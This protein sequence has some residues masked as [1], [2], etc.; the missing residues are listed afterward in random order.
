MEAYYCRERAGAQIDLTI[1]LDLAL[2]ICKNI[3][4][5]ESSK[6][7]YTRAMTGR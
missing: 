6:S 1:H 3:M 5:E 2:E 7:I 4:E